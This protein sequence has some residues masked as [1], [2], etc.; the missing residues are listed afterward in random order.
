[1][2]TL[3]NDLRLAARTVAK[4]PSSAIITSVT[5]ALGIGLCTTSFSLVYGVFFRGLGVPE[6]DRLT[7]IYR[8]NPSQDVQSMAVTQHDFYD[9]REQQTSF[10][11]L[12]AFRSGT[13]NISGTEGPERYNGAWVSANAFALLRERAVLGSTFRE[14]DDAAGAPLTVV[15]GH[16]VWD[17]RYES[18]PGIVGRS[19]TVNGEAATIL[20]VMRDGFMF[21]Q[22]QALW[23]AQ[24]D[25]RAT[26]PDRERSRT[27][28]VFGRLKPGVSLDQAERE[29]ALIA[30]RL[31]REYPK[32][33]EGVTTAF[34][35]FIEDDTGPELVAVFGAMQVATI[36]VLLIACANVANLLLARATLRTKESAV[37]TALGA[38]PFRVVLPFF[39]ETVVLATSGALLGTGIAYVGIRLFD[40]ATQGVG[41]PYYMEFALDV[42][43]L[44]FV[45][46][47]TL[48]TAL[49][50]GAAPAFQALKTDVNETLKD[51]TRGS[52][53]VR[54][55]RVTRVLVTAEIALSCALL[56]GA[57]LM[58]KSIVRLR[59]YDFP[60]ATANVFTA[61]VGLFAT[62]YPDTASRWQFFRDLLVR[63]QGI[64]GAQAAALVSS[65]PGGGG[66]GGRI[67]IE[68]EAYA[69]EQD[70]PR[71]GSVW[72][73]PDFFQ[74]FEVELLR[75]RSFTDHDDAEA[76][77]VAIINQAFAEAHFPGQD[78]IGRRFREGTTPVPGASPPQPSDTTP[79]WLTI[80]GVAPNLRVPLNDP[81]ETSRSEYYV[82]V[83][84]RDASFLSI[85]VR[86]A[87][88][89][90]LA[91]APLVRE[92][93]R[94][95]D[96]D[97]PIYQVYSMLGF[98]RFNTW[99]IY[100][101]GT[102]FI[103]FG[104]AALFM[105]SVGLYGVLAFSV[106]RRVREM[107]IRMAVGASAQDVL[108]LVLRQ[109]VIQIAFGLG[110]GLVLAYGLTRVIRILMFEVTP[111]DPLVFIAISMVIIGVG[112][113]ASFVPARRATG[114][115]PIVA[116][117]YE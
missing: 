68:G 31:A 42:P 32:S 113:L 69:T 29:M 10:E 112:L 16:D 87:S 70:Y 89:D 64:P 50:A 7:L 13:A 25:E 22:D 74:T 94:T 56:V 45:L 33:N 20:G 48:L 95:L 38:S 84:Q 76:P 55:S 91:L 30:D 114:V 15:L 96:P 57:G 21:P 52:S 66:G 72:I 60:F 63:L 5:L 12:A 26:A 73:T 4:H 1:M 78:P 19:I 105:A 37:R 3:W 65:L 24:R 102:V 100:V 98:I 17:S 104:A 49:V 36:F 34:R 79:D 71:A 27:L 106:S 83:Q 88:G 82:P 99:F 90:A 97:L 44:V 2:G 54:G 43:V 67:A 39:A 115:D 110:V 40:G 51:E 62:E 108:T 111:Q 14:G 18:D 103:V 59:N 9:W 93:V 41:K 28:S 46:G 23:I 8:R 101:F 85:A 58:V 86:T 47:V 117:R 80:V 6:A 77:P 75:G 81:D 61:R 35:T 11:G 107:G 109:G 116:L 92:Q 53:S